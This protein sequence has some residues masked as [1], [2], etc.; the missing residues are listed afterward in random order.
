MDKP[1]YRHWKTRN[2][3][4]VDWQ[5][6]R[7]YFHGAYGS[8]ES[9]AEYEAFCLEHC[10][11]EPVARRRD[12]P[13]VT[14]IAELYA[15][16]CEATFPATM[17]NHTAECNMLAVRELIF[18]PG[19]TG[20]IGDLPIARIGPKVIQAF[21][22]HMTARKTKAGGH[23]S[24]RTV[25]DRL[26]RVKGFF[27]WAVANEYAPPEVYMGIQA[28]PSVRRGR[29]QAVDNPPRRPV[30]WRDVEPVFDE[31]APHL[32]PLLWLQWYTGARSGS[33]VQACP[34]QFS[35]D[36]DI[37]AIMLWRPRHKTEHVVDDLVIPI[38]PRCLERIGHLLG[39]CPTKPLA[40][41]R[42]ARNNGRASD[43]YTSRAWRRALLRAQ[44]RAIAKATA[45]HGAYVPKHWTPHQMRHARGQLVRAAYGLEGAQSALGHET[46]QAAQI[47]SHRRAEVAKQIALEIG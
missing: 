10:G 44:D 24:R 11:D 6:Q 19:P 15:E 47:Y 46:I 29:S 16:H 43:T 12:G 1:T 14:D 42:T 26:G 45:R 35:P 40:C 31:L 21:V 37:P 33:V 27:K 20:N 18:A 41:P 4:F 25:N 2:K 39:G 32:R 30:D 23:L 8:A 3:G 38:G 28:V 17:T 9:M 34:G 13:T 5:G 22:D 36:P 7:T